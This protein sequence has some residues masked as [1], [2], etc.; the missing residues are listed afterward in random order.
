M[1]SPKSRKVARIVG[2]VLHVLIGAM[3]IMAGGF[4][5]LGMFPKEAVEEMAKMGVAD[6]LKLIGAGELIAALLLII[7]KTTKLGT[8]ATSGFWG[9][10]ICIHMTHND[11]YIPWAVALALTWVGAY[12]RHPEMLVNEPQHKPSVSEGQAEL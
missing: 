10:V 11:F 6:K 3:M 4:K 2:L 9:G 12:L 1:T 7:P 5:L 8:L